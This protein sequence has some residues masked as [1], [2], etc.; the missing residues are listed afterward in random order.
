MQIEFEASRND[1][2]KYKYRFIRKE[3]QKLKQSISRGSFKK[4]NYDTLP[5]DISNPTNSLKH[6]AS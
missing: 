4:I 2:L 6:S 5:S 3:S 1:L